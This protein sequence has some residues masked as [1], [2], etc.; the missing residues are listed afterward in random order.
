MGLTVCR[1]ET[2]GPLLRCG[3]SLGPARGLQSGS[4]PQHG[5]RNALWVG[6]AGVGEHS[7]HLILWVFV[8]TRLLWAEK[9]QETVTPEFLTC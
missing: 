8:V 4:R 2:P 7:L 9:G 6:R 1:A 3:T 5:R